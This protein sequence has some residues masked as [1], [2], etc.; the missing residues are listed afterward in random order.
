MQEYNQKLVDEKTELNIVDYINDFNSKFYQVDVSFMEEFIDLVSRYNEFCIPHDL[1]FKYGVLNEHNTS[2]VKRLLDQYQFLEEKD[3]SIISPELGLNSKVGRPENIYMLKPKTF[4]KCLIRSLKTTKYADYYLLLE[5]CITYY[6]N[7]QLMLKEKYIV[8][9]RNKMNNNN[10]IKLLPLNSQPTLD[11]FIIVRCDKF[12]QYP[13]AII[14]GSDRNVKYV[15]R[16]HGFSKADIILNLL[17]PSH[18]N[19]TK[20]IKEVLKYKF[21][22]KCF[23]VRQRIYTRQSDEKVFYGDEYDFDDDDDYIMACTRY[24]NIVGMP[25]DT[26]LAA[27]KEIDSSRF[28]Y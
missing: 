10:E 14:K 19:F 16:D 27:L 17:V 5:D 11:H 26:F 21:Q 25:E 8:E 18:Q 28:D 24:F 13:Y 20:K 3:Y 12:K 6:N 2:H 4:K 7:Y 1:L 15:M 23:L 9:L 22:T